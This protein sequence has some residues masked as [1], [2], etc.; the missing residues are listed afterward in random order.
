MCLNTTLGNVP[1]DT[2]GLHRVGR[3]SDTGFH[4]RHWTHPHGL[5]WEI[6][7]NSSGCAWNLRVR[8]PKAT[9]PPRKKSTCHHR[10]NLI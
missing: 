6:F 7:V 9:K 8:N 10:P 3:L 2:A 4:T 5:S 1:I